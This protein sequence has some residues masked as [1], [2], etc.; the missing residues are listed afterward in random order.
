[1]IGEYEVLEAYHRVL[2]LRRHRAEI[3]NSREETSAEEEERLD[4]AIDHNDIELRYLA[5]FVK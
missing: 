2:K 3:E 1:M 5:Q 4:A